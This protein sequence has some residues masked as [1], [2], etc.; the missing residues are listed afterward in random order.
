MAYKV[1]LSPSNQPRNKCVLGH[2]E[3]DHCEELVQRMLPLLRARGIEYRLRNPNKSMSTSV[4]EATAWGAQLYM[5][6]HTNAAS[7]KARGTRFG[8]A[9]GRKDSMEVGKIFKQ[10]WLEIY[11]LHDKVFV[12]PYDFYEARAPKCPSVYTETIFHDHIDDAKWFHANMDIIAQNFVE[13]I[14]D[15]L[16]VPSEPVVRVKLMREE[17]AKALNKQIGDIIA[18]SMEEYLLGVVPAEVGNAPIEAAKAQAIAARTYAL[19]VT[20]GGAIVNDGSPHQA[21]RYNRSKTPAYAN[22]HEGVRATAGQVLS[23]KGEIIDKAWYSDCNG[24]TTLQSGE[25]WSSD[26]PFLAHKADPWTAATKKPKNGHGVGLSQ[27]GSAYAASIGVSHRPILSFYY[28]GTDIGEN[29]KPKPVDVEKTPLYLAKA[30]TV[31]PLSLNIWSSPKK[32]KSLG[33]IPKGAAVKVLEE[34]S[35]K[36]ALIQYGVITGYVDRKYLKKDPV[37]KKVPYKAIVK[38]RLPRSLNLWALPTKGK[39]LGKI[40]RDAV[41]DVLDETTKPLVRIRYLGTVGYSDIKYLK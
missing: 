11:P 30:N 32:D 17:N 1:Y 12:C 38:T 19:K 26:R 34:V 14:A 21:Y 31:R 41:V 40:P 35:S 39:S 10:N 22:A 25:V 28:P 6:I 23:Y 24:G 20:S 13:S 5:P 7:G 8:Y 9:P 4:A 16:K 33:K 2:S 27:V 18:L 37:P 29:Y 36:W 3:K 15:F